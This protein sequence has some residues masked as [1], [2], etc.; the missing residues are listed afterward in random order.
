MTCVKEF[1]ENTVL[2]PDLIRTQN[3]GGPGHQVDSESGG[4]RFKEGSE[5]KRIRTQTSSKH[6]QKPRTVPDIMR[7]QTTGRPRLHTDPDVKQTWT[8][9][10]HS[11]RYHADPDYRK[12]KT[13]YGPRQNDSDPHIRWIQTSD[14]TK[15]QT[16]A[17]FRQIHTLG[18]P[19]RQADPDFKR[20]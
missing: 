15:F 10:S 12:T 18:V 7:T 20:I 16:D 9:T 6:G 1:R 4:P 3:L 8:K 13:S 17:D 19:R 14:G 2:L 11:P 5:V